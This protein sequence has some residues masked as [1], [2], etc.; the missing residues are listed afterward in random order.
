MGN[1]RRFYEISDSSDDDDDDDGEMPVLALPRRAAVLPTPTFLQ[2]LNKVNAERSH[3]RRE[4]L[5]RLQRR[6]QERSD[7]RRF[8]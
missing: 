6:D 5:M 7:R 8:I 3:K 1:I 2:L 4:E